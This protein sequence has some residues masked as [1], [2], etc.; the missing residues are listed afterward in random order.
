MAPSTARVHFS[1]WPHAHHAVYACCLAVLVLSALLIGRN[2]TLWFDEA[3]YF[4]NI[5]DA[6]WDQLFGLLPFYDQAAP[7]GYSAIL[8]IMQAVFGL[9]EILLRL[10]S[11]VALALIGVVASQFPG[12]SKLERALFCILL[13]SSSTLFQYSAY[14]KHYVWEFFFIILVMSQN[15][16]ESPVYRRPLLRVSCLFIAIICSVQAALTLAALGLTVALREIGPLLWNWRSWAAGGER[17]ALWRKRIHDGFVMLLPLILGSIVEIVKYVLVARE[18]TTIVV[19]NYKYTFDFGYA[20]QEGYLEFY[21]ASIYNIIRFNFGE[22]ELSAFLF[23]SMFLVGMAY[24]IYRRRKEASTFA[25]LIV[26]ALLLNAAGFYPLLPGRY[27][28]A[29][30]LSLSFFMALGV[31][32]LAEPL[33]PGVKLIAAAAFAIVCT[34]TP[35]EVTMLHQGQ[36]ARQ[37]LAEV[38]SQLDGKMPQPRAILLTLGSQPLVDAYLGPFGDPAACHNSS[39]KVLG[40]TNRCSQLRQRGKD[41]AFVGSHTPWFIMNYIAHVSFGKGVRDVEASTVRTW[42]ADYIDFLFRQACTVPSATIA[43]SHLTRSFA[44]AID[45]RFMAGGTVEKEIDENR[46]GEEGM[47][48]GIVLR[49]RRATDGA[50]GCNS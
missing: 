36:Q 29:L 44:R 3:T 38:R 23:L 28:L 45:E 9:N 6:R 50:G 30:V 40:W 2:V 34:V 16:P 11:F 7:V 35:I 5:R 31:A 32:A 43:I 46:R 48:D 49:W 17:T 33:G 24:A 8:K 14:M 39:P 18:A 20:Y 42:T 19:E 22:S 4:V 26:I 37:L 1:W 12:I 15:I 41:Y 27:S 25:L 47:G 10:P 21:T 13:L